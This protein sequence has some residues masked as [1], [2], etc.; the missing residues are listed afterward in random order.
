MSFLILSISPVLKV[1]G[2]VRAFA[3]AYSVKFSYDS[4]PFSHLQ[5]NKD[6]QVTSYF[7]AIFFVRGFG[8]IDGFENDS[9]VF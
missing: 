7:S 5:M 2:A 1:S 6:D 3:K 8:D 4:F 9:P